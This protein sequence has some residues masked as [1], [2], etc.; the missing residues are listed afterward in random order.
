MSVV[1][2]TGFSDRSPKSLEDLCLRIGVDAL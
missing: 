1:M 2:Y